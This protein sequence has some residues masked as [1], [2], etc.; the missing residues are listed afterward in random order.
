MT[1]PIDP[2]TPIVHMVR[3]EGGKYA[4]AFKSGGYVAK[5]DNFPGALKNC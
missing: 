2:H 5:G 1:K 3:A 4:H